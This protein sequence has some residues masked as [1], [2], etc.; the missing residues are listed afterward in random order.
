METFRNEGLWVGRE[1]PN[2]ESTC[3]ATTRIKIRRIKLSIIHEYG[4][5]IFIFFIVSKNPTKGEKKRSFI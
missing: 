4:N 3:T 5:V 1:E 2:R